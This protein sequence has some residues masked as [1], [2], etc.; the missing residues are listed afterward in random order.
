MPQSGYTPI[1][2]YSSSTPTSQPAAGN[3]TNDTK[4][5]ELAVNIADGKLFYK[6]S[7][8]NVQ[9]IADKTWV[10]TVTNVSALTIG[11]TGTD[12]SSTVANPTSTPVITLN[13]PTASAANRGA[14]SSTDWSTFNNKQPALVSGVNIKTV[15]G[16]T[17]L[18]SGDLGTITTAYG[19]TGLASF[20]QGDLLYYNS[21]TTLTALAKNTTATRYLSNT[22]T[23]NNP[24]WAQIDLSNGV[25]GTLPVANGGTGITSFGTGVATWLGTPSSANLAAAVTDETGSGALVFGTSPTLTTPTIA[26]I[27]SASATEPPKLANSS[28]TEYGQTVKAWVNGNGDTGAI[29]T[30]F[31]CSSFSKSA[32][33]VYVMSFTNAVADANFSVVMGYG[34]SLTS[35]QAFMSRNGSTASSV[36][37]RM[38]NPAL[39]L[40]NFDPI[41]LAIF[42]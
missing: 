25:T 27:R 30:S 35:N 1:Q 22:G 18:G 8:N 34:D 41:Y 20:S 42:R 33:G 11:T 2:L 10:G 14:L 39:S 16:T 36:T 17:L 29:R 21:G 15:N 24:A 38:W 40:T 28:G 26:E 7:S 6:D 5:S 37:V 3:L 23:N 32:T 9:T 31:N 19:G 12:L 13:V 4:G